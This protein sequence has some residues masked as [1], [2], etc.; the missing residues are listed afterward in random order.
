MAPAP[1]A[2][3]S[4]S[5]P[6][7]L[8]SV[9]GWRRMVEHPCA[10]LPA[11]Q[12]RLRFFR[13]DRLLTGPEVDL[14]LASGERR[15][16]PRLYRT[17]CPSCDACVPVRLDVHRLELRRTQRRALARNR[18]LVVEVG[19]AVES[20]EAL[21]LF[22]RHHEA[23]GYG[24]GRSMD[25]VDFRSTFYESCTETWE[26]RYS[27]P[28]GPLVGV[29]IVDVG[30]LSLN[31]NQT[32][33]DPDHGARSL[34]T[35]SVLFEADLARRTGRRWLYLGFFVDGSAPMAYKVG[36]RP[37][38]RLVPHSIPPRWDVHP[39]GPTRPLPG[40]GG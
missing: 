36:F 33:W 11:R 30:Q 6:P 3:S 16:G 37:H 20:R 14:A 32:F 1:G 19:P 26:I 34:G 9:L 18:D 8:G 22:L 40:T 25:M 5:A 39:P 27:L 29:A 10:Y 4:P 13:P 31:A 7:S 12:S 24:S 38:E 35:F 21:D 28:G 2:P 15:L 23:R 17:A